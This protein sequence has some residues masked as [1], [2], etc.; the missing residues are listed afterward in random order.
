MSDT[1]AENYSIS[2]ENL[3]INSL[4]KIEYLLS[5]NVKLPLIEHYHKTKIEFIIILDGMQKFYINSVLHTFY[6]GDVA[7][8]KPNQ[9]HNAV[10]N[11]SDNLTEILWFQL[12]L[13]EVENFLSLSGITGREFYKMVASINTRKFQAEPLFLRNFV[14]CFK[15]FS[16]DNI[17]NK[18]KAQ[19]LFV[20]C[21]SKLLETKSALDM[22]STDIEYAKEYI[23]LH[24]DE[25][26]DMDILSSKSNLS[27]SQFKE[28]FKS[29]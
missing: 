12:D 10:A 22:L 25:V 18:I 20:Y 7:I 5:Y 14:T 17:N 2:Q 4:A 15:L 28:K 27:L 3:S 1:K 16:S 26:I 29:Q 6:S 8:I 11:S 24:F 9:L 21:L 13:S 19:G 23:H